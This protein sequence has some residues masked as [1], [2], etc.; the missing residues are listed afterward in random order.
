MRSPPSGALSLLLALSHSRGGEVS[1]SASFEDA[2]I[3]EAFGD[4]PDDFLFA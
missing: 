3:L 2:L 4:V 1:I